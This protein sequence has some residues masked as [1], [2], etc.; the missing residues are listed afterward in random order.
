MKKTN[1]SE[2][3]IISRKKEVLFSNLDDELLAIDSQAGFCYSMNETA[4]RIWDMLSSPISVNQICSQLCKEF[5][6]EQ[7]VCQQEVLPLLQSL[8]EAEL[9]QV[10]DEQSTTL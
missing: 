6:V 4:G 5:S 8:L 10:H 2:N 1:I 9:I 7:S 3:S